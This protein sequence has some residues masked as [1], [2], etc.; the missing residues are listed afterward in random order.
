LNLSKNTHSLTL[1]SSP[2][3]DAYRQS[4]LPLPELPSLKTVNLW[5]VT[6]THKSMPN[7]NT[8]MA[9][10][11]KGIISACVAEWL[12]D[13]D[14][15]LTP[16]ELTTRSDERINK[17]LLAAFADAYALP[18]LLQYAKSIPSAS[19]YTVAD[20]AVLF[21]AY[22]GAV[23]KDWGYEATKEWLFALMDWDNMTMLQ[24]LHEN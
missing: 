3:A 23:H 4:E 14:P 7:N 19:H 9:V 10:L 11:G 20:G 13:A 24:T 1:M 5:D 21:E 17:P 6:F 16:A 22:V 2:I 12:I 8:V 18:P 15:G